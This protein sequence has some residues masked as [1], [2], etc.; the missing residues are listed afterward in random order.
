MIVLI[1]N[2]IFGMDNQKTCIIVTAYILIYL[3]AHSSDNTDRVKLCLMYGPP[4][5]MEGHGMAYSYPSSLEYWLGTLQ[6]RMMI[7]TIAPTFCVHSLLILDHVA[8][9]YENIS[10]DR[11]VIS[12]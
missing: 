12:S 1:V 7:M 2:I 3:T 11:D 6:P 8:Q 10:K 5:K 4:T 9:E